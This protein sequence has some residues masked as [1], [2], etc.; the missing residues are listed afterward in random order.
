MRTLGVNHK[1][2]PEIRN[3]ISLPFKN[4]KVKNVIDGFKILDYVYFKSFKK[5]NNFLHNSYFDAGL[6][7]C[8]VNH[9]FNSVSFS[10]R[11]WLTTFETQVPRY[12]NN[13]G[14]IE[15]KA[16]R[17]LS[18]N[19]CK[20]IIA[21]SDS[22]KNIQLEFIKNKYPSSFD[23]IFEKI[24]II[25]PPQ[26]PIINSYNE[27]QLNCERINFTIIGSDFF[28][29]G[30]LEVLRVF[31]R[32]LSKGANICLNVVSSM[33]IGDYASRASKDSLDEANAILA[34]NQKFINHHFWMKNEDVLNLLKSTHVALL[35]TY[36][37]TYGYSVLEAQAAGC[38]TITTDVRALPEINDSSCG[39][40]INVKKDCY[41]NAILNSK[42]DR[43][44]LSKSI[45]NQLE[46]Y[47]T[48]I[49]DSPSIIEK[50]GV[51]SLNRIIDSHCSEKVAGRLENIY[52]N[53]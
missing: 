45:E 34:R 4:Y 26:K 53:V 47:I 15:S 41:G 23:S 28:R 10:S 38:V 52:E 2:Y 18:S 40:L 19:A 13:G 11:P 42:K 14:F 3:I 51:Q 43:H 31:D 5:S 32:L 29:K 1:G 36:A 33:Q 16:I 50:M 9:F 6:N 27:K 25:H 30:G 20:R 12:N 44:E 49:L 21:L 22:A 35:P 8:D 24:E 37:D 7:N 17:C 48:K 46:S 39:F